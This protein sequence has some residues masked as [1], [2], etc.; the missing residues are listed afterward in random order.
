MPSSAS[1]LRA[2]AAAAWPARW[3]RAAVFLPSLSLAACSLPATRVIL[4][5]QDHD[6]PSAV[7]VRNAA[8]ETRL[9]RPYQRATAVAGARA[10]P[11]ADTVDPAEIRRA[12]AVLFDLAPLV[13]AHFT[14]YFETGQSRLI[15]A[16][17]QLMQTVLAAADAR[18]GGDI[19]I[20]GHTDTRGTG[21]SNDQ[22]SLQRAWLVRQML[23]DHGFPADRIEAAGRGERELLV[24]TPD[25][26]DEP[27]NRRVVIVVR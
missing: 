11:P 18:S 16:S 26:T 22:L 17:Q 12:N 24:Q 3:M 25:E 4:L 1:G 5:P 6:I 8:G 20:T 2:V 19:I 27:R 9:D 10:A 15:P 13:P 23:V 21:S 14:V 7:V